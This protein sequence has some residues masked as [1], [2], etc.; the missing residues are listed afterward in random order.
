MDDSSHR[1]PKMV[2]VLVTSRFGVLLLVGAYA[3]VLMMGHRT[4]LKKAV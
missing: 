3:S 1:W 2:R 4:L